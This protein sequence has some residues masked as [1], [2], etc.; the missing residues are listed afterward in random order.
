VLEEETLVSAKGGSLRSDWIAA[1]LIPLL[2][3]PSGSF[4][5]QQPGTVASGEGLKIVVVEGEGNKNNIRLRSAGGI[6]VKVTD[7]AEKPVPGAEVTFQVPSAGP[8]GRFYDWLQT[9]TV[10]TNTEGVARVSGFTPNQETGQWHMRVL[11]QHGVRSGQA[12]IP[13][14][15]VVG[16]GASSGTSRKKMWIAIGVIGLAAAIAGGVAAASGGDSTD[17]VTGRRPVVIAPG[18]VTVGGPR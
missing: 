11:A 15:N 10:K 18:T 7:E 17:A 6:A 16:E 4:A 3:W 14:N 2:L 9:Q 5:G 13:Q 1:A 8:S 12:M